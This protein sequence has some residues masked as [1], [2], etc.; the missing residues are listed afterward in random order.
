MKISPTKK[1][2]LSIISS[3]IVTI[4][5]VF[6]FIFILGKNPFE[7]FGLM[8][9]ESFGTYYG[10]GQ[11]LFKATP[12]IIISCGLA[13][14]FHASLFNIGGEGQ[15]NAGTFVFAILLIQFSSMPFILA[16]PLALIIAF[17]TGGL[18]GFIP[19]LIKVKKGVSEVIT[20]IMM[21]FVILS[22][23]NYF[24]LNFF[25][26]KATV[27]TEDIPINFKLSLISDFI[28]AFKGSSLNFTFFIAIVIAVIIYFLI[29]KTK[30]GFKIRAT[31]FNEIASG[32]IG[33][34]PA[35]VILI[36][37]FIGAGV[38]AL[39]GINFVSGYKG[40]YEF[41][42][43][44]NIGFSSIAVTLLA[45]N[46]PIGIIFS[47]ILFAFLD[48]GGLAIN[49]IIPKE[50]VLVVEAIVILSIISISKII[51]MKF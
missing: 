39:A 40:Y 26:V 34:K 46:N 3:V 21:N 4:L 12:L 48:F 50:I 2:L 24:L 33:L 27:H 41:G 18:L 38:I 16:F 32:Y 22:L 30:L 13:I 23:I 1:I 19:G 31:G 11:I 36:S 44:N 29:Y 51:D 49:Q 8:L 9:S 10:F 5:I 45:K 42:F 35:K 47:A 15:Y 17:L 6:L 20:T 14:C 37:F 7:I 25:A 28:P 43:S